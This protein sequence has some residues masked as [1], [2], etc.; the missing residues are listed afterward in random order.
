MWSMSLRQSV[1]SAILI[2]YLTN[3]TLL[4][5][6]AT[7]DQLGSRYFNQSLSHTPKIHL[8]WLV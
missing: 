5:M 6:A 4:S 2:E 7:S 3:G 1:F 8:S